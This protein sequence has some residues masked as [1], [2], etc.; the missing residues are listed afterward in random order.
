MEWLSAN[1]CSAALK[2]GWLI[3]TASGLYAMAII[4]VLIVSAP[5]YRQDVP[6]AVT[7][8]ARKYIQWFLFA[9]QLS[10]LGVW[11]AGGYYTGSELLSCYVQ[12]VA[13]GAA[14]VIAP[15][16]LLLMFTAANWVGRSGAR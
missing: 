8:T 12:T 4:I 10:L 9:A 2:F 13:L 1:S 11:G 7:E 14:V 6:F 5:A 3:G 16:M 15:F